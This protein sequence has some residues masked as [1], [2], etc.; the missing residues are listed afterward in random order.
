[1]KVLTPLI[2]L[3]ELV[4]I[5]SALTLLGSYGKTTCAFSVEKVGSQ[6]LDLAATV[7]CGDMLHSVQVSASL[8]S[9]ATDS[10]KFQ[11][12]SD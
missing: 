7:V 5:W 11:F 8:L 4:K 2:P 12:S 10:R 9:L 1:M 3:R 6:T